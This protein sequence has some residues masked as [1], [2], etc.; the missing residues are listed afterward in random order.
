MRLGIVEMMPGDF[1]TWTGEH[2]SAVR[3][4]GFTGFG[5]H[6]DGELAFDIT[7]EDCRRYHEFMAGEDLD[8]AQFAILYKECLFSPDA[9]ERDA[10]TAKINRGT[11]I[12]AALGAQSFLLRPGSLSPHG[13]WTP[14]RDNHLPQS[15]ERLI[16]TLQPIARKAEAEGVIL[17]MET[18][19]VSIMDP[20]AACRDIVADVGFDHFRLIMDAVNHFGSIQTVYRSTEFLNHIF[21]TMGPLAPV[22][23]LKDLKVSPGLVV[24]IDQ[25]IP[26]EGELDLALMLQR[27]DALVAT[28]PQYAS[29]RCEHRL[30]HPAARLPSSGSGP[31]HRPHICLTRH[32]FRSHGVG[33]KVSVARCISPRRRPSFL[34]VSVVMW[35]NCRRRGSHLY[36]MQ[37]RVPESCS[38]A[39]TICSPVGVRTTWGTGS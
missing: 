10:V 32:V 8:L 37:G 4:L 3:E 22:A 24:H 17:A 28:S 25:E 19:V 29:P 13:S 31:R 35:P 38:D 21:D 23:H 33:W 11:E 7:P 2:T 15:R 1:R 5:F 18:H 14:H 39:T 12:A 20:P 36:R 16:E 30:R 9:A 6:L 27:F 26:G 34:A